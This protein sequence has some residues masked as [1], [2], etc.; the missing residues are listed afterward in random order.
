MVASVFPC[1]LPPSPLAIGGRVKYIVDTPEVIWGSLDSSRF[2]DAARRYL[3]AEQVMLF[4][5][6]ESFVFDKQQS[7]CT[8]SLSSAWSSGYHC[9]TARIFT[10]GL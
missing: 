7:V 6:T 9:C 4:D 1:F 2:L 3:R 5:V 8:G 10:L